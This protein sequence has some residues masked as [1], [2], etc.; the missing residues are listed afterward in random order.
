MTIYEYT[1]PVHFASA[2]INGDYTGLNDSEE[3]ELN[4]WLEARQNEHV[5]QGHWCLKDFEQEPYF[6]WTNDINDLG[7]DVLDFEFAVF[8]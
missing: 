3:K 7:S 2:I 1:I 5:G 4:S 6:S 8:N